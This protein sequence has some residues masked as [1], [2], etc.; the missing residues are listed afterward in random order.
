MVKWLKMGFKLLVGVNPTTCGCITQVPSQMLAFELL[1][2]WG[3]N[4]ELVSVLPGIQKE[5]D[6]DCKEIDATCG[7]SRRNHLQ[8]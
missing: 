8:R 5:L 6:G 1:V 7:Q 4:L 3:C 2:N